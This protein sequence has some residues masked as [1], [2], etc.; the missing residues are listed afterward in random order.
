[1]RRP[2]LTK[3]IISLRSVK[4]KSQETGPENSS[5]HLNMLKKIPSLVMPLSSSNYSKSLRRNSSTALSTSSGAPIR[6]K[7]ISYATSTE[8]KAREGPQ[9]Q[10][11]LQ[12][13]WLSRNYAKG[14]SSRP[15][16]ASTKSI[17]LSRTLI[18]KPKE[19]PSISWSIR[20]KVVLN[21]KGIKSE[22]RKDTLDSQSAQ[23]CF[24]SS[25]SWLIIPSKCNIWSQFPSAM[26]TVSITLRNISTWASRPKIISEHCFIMEREGMTIMTNSRF[27]LSPLMNFRFWIWF[28]RPCFTIISPLRLG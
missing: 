16:A 1:M 25:Q 8:K 26:K 5:T 9:S 21:H 17:I 6:T 2:W 22:S 23:S 3:R 27:I 28:A 20:T 11:I 15:S 14:S 13:W 7:F 4:A 10:L 18:A 19:G 24:L 12:I